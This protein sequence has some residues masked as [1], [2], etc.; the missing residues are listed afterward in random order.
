ML[1]FRWPRRHT[2]THRKIA[3]F[4]PML[5]VLED[6]IA[7]SHTEVVAIHDGT[8][9]PGDPHNDVKLIS[10]KAG[11]VL[12]MSAATG[13]RANDYD[14][15]PGPNPLTTVLVSLP[16]VTG[17][18]FDFNEDGSW[19]YGAPVGFTG[20][21]SFPDP[22]P[23][24]PLPDGYTVDEGGV[25]ASVYSAVGYGGALILPTEGATMLWLSST[26]TTATDQYQNSLG[27][28][29]TTGTIVRGPSA[30]LAAGT[31]VSLD[32]YV[33]T[34]DY[35]PY[36]DFALGLVN[37]SQLFLFT[38]TGDPNY[39]SGWQNASLTIAADGQYQ[40]VLVVSNAIDTGVATELYIDNVVG[41]P[42][43]DPGVGQNAMSMVSGPV[44][45]QVS[46]YAYRQVGGKTTLVHENTRPRPSSRSPAGT[47][48]DKAALD[49]YF[50]V[51]ADQSHFSLISLSIKRNRRRR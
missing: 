42:W 27:E 38:H 40:L 11:S 31:Q 2:H 16:T 32:W 12:N 15:I 23:G 3:R 47:R 8:I 18:F 19:S 4:R 30:F 21:V 44:S 6:R 26:G 25:A 39:D 50:T 20:P 34:A 10:M 29:G 1:K 14:T 45:R 7:L 13:V 22:E 17:T 28:P 36:H 9:I 46:G 51:L 24:G 5:E 43:S 48:I 35:D 49:A 33:T 37:G 41:F